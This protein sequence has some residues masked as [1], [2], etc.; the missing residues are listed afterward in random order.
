MEDFRILSLKEEK[1]LSTEELRKYYEALREYL[2][3]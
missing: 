2:S 3:T 1:E